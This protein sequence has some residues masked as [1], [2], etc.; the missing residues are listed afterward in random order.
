MQAIGY[1]VY[2][3]P[4]VLKPFCYFISL[5][6]ETLGKDRGNMMKAEAGTSEN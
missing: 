3:R 1:Y 4:D 2:T 6:Y 5:L